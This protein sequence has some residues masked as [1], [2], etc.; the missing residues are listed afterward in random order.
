MGTRKERDRLN[1]VTETIIGCAYRVS[2]TLGHGFLEK[3]YERAM[4][5]E[6]GSQGLD[7]E[8][9]V[10]ITVHYLKATGLRVCL[11]LNFGGPKVEVRRIVNRF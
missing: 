6:V 7:V 2:N 8:T 9:Q 4:V 1:A 11:L 5:I 3:L 10:P